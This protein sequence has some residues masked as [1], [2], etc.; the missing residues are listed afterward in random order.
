MQTSIPIARAREMLTK[1]SKELEKKP[2]IGAIQVTRRG[3]PAL[4][5]MSWDLYESLVETM[6]ILGD[7][8]L[9][10]DIRH[11]MKDIEEGN[12]VSWEEVKRRLEI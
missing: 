12:F 10:A 2:Q 5:I 7:E 6:E 4:A 1:L 3:K 11:G 8:E 9:M